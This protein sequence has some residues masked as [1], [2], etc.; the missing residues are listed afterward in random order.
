LGPA[1]IKGLNACFRE[2]ESVG[3][4]PNHVFVASV[5]LKDFSQITPASN[6]P[7]NNTELTIIYKEKDHLEEKLCHIASQLT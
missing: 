6:Q 3:L 4:T 7:K 5:C 1:M 2:V